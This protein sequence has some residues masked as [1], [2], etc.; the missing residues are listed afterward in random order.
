MPVKDVLSSRLALAIQSQ[1]VVETERGLG[2]RE[3]MPDTPEWVHPDVASD[4]AHE[5]SDTHAQSIEVAFAPV[6]IV[7]VPFM[8]RHIKKIVARA[9]ERSAKAHVW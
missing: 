1:V 2:Q 9:R 6:T 8:G 4:G 3:G 7:I 5:T